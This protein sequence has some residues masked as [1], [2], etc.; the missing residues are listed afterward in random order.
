MNV[1]HGSVITVEMPIRSKCRIC[2]DFGKG[3]YVTTDLD[4]AKKWALL[5][6][7]SDEVVF[8]SGC[9]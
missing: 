7:N 9:K 4:Q 3:F 8:W 1:N 5:K 6:Q 2:T